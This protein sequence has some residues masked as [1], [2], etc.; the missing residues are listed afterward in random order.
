MEIFGNQTPKKS[1]MKSQQNFLYE[2][3]SNSSNLSFKRINSLIPSNIFKNDQNNFQISYKESVSIKKSCKI[4]ITKEN[5]S[6]NKSNKIQRNVE[7]K[8]DSFANFVNNI[9]K[10]ES[11]LNKNVIAKSSKKQNDKIKSNYIFN[12][13][14]Y[15]TQTRR[16]SAINSHLGLSQFNNPENSNMN[17]FN[18]NTNK[19]GLT[20]N[21]NYKSPAIHKKLCEK[22]NNL[23]HKKNLTKNEKELILNFFNKINISPK[24]R[25]YNRD[26]KSP[27]LKNRQS[28]FKK[29]DKPIENKRTDKDNNE[30]EGINNIILYELKDN[31]SKISWLKNIC[32]CLETEEY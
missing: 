4:K 29:K 3:N 19:E 9:Y 28:K 16:M 12:K 23:L 6:R 14:I 11:H 26:I 18:I 5:L 30:N 13:S 17:N 27:R 21:S 10:N 20:I 2:Q 32:C 7:N 25:M 24:H 1:L 8:N 15:N 22:I 31:Q